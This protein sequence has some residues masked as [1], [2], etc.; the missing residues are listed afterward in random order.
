MK[1][2]LTEENLFNTPIVFGN[3]FRKGLEKKQRVYE[4]SKD[5]PKLIKTIMDYMQD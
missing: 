4:E 3:F 1:S 2:S 5:F